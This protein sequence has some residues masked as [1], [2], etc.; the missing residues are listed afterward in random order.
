MALQRI[1]SQ[2]CV[3]RKGIRILSISST[4]EFQQAML[5]LLLMCDKITAKQEMRLTFQGNHPCPDPHQTAQSRGVDRR[6]HTAE[7]EE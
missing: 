3:A 5:V 4:A 7:P 2:S 1:L 6:A